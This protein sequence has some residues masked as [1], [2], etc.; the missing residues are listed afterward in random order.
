MNKDKSLL[1]SIDSE[2]NDRINQFIN[3]LRKVCN[4]RELNLHEP[5]FSGNETKYLEECVS[6]NFVSSVGIFVSK[7][8]KM[9]SELTGAKH[10]IATVNGTSALHLSLLCLGIRSKDEV[11]LPTLT[12]VGSANSIRY[13]N[14][15]PHF[16][17]IS[18]DDLNL[19]LDKLRDHLKFTVEKHHVYSINK[20]TNNRIA[21]I[22]PVHIYGQPVDMETLL[23]IASEYKITIIEDAAESLGSFLNKKHTGTFGKIGCLSFNGNKIVTTGGGG[24]ILT[25]DDML[26]KQIR[27][28]ST[29]AKI[30]HPWELSHDEIGYNYRMPNINAALGCAQ[31]ELFSNLLENKRNLHMK[32]KKEL[33]GIPWL[34]LISE[35]KESISNYWLNTVILKNN[36]DCFQKRLIETCHKEKIFLRPSWKPLHLLPMFQSCPKSE[37]NT[38]S[39]LQKKIVNLPSSAFL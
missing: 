11:L 35:N 3:I 24:A 15:I 12:F 37:L 38:A 5:F 18:K 36:E 32:Y 14:A 16:C 33:D 19:D 13:C 27:H 4:R 30:A 39:F 1:G 2:S 26:A 23:S 6:T 21:A 31:L 29:T 17:D 20:Y 34:R 9:L 10:V 28:M 22:M 8:E 7:F 25:D